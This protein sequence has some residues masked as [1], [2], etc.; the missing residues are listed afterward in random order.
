MNPPNSSPPITPYPEVP[1]MQPSQKLSLEVLE[2]REVPALFGTPWPNANNL[3][4]SFAQDWTSIAGYSQD[5]LGWGQPSQLFSKM[6]GAGTAT[7]WQT[8]ILRAFQTWAVNANINIGL[9]PD[10]GSPFGPLSLAPNAGSSGDIRIGAYLASP[11][12]IAINQPY[13]PISGAWSGDLLYN[14]SKSFSIGNKLASFDLFT[15]TLNEA[16]NIFGLEDRNDPNSALYGH[17]IGVKAGLIAADVTALQSLYGVRT[18]D[19][20]DKAKNNDSINTQTVLAPY[21]AP[22][23]S[24]KKMVSANGADLTTLTD[25][26]HYEFKVNTTSMTVRLETVGKSL[27]AAK[28]SVYDSAD[29]FIATATSA[30]PLAMQDLV[31]TVNGLTAGKFYTV[32]VEKAADDAFGIGKYDL[33][34]GFG[35]NPVIP[36]TATAATFASDGGTNESISTASALIAVSGSANTSYLELGRI[37]SAT[38]VD[39]YKLNSPAI[40]SA[41]MTVIVDPAR[42]YGLYTKVTAYDA[43]GSVVP[44]EVLANGTD[45]RLVIQVAN[46]IASKVYSLKVQSVGRN[47][48]GTTGD[49]SLSVDFTRPAVPMTTVAA[50]T[51]TASRTIDYTTFAVPEAKVFH[52]TLNATTT[53]ASVASGVRMIIYNANSHIIASFSTDAGTTSTGAVMLGSGTYYMR[54]EGAT[55]TGVPLA[56]LSYS[57]RTVVLSDPI[58]PYAPPDPTNPPPL[59]PDYTTNH[60]ADPFYIALSLLNPW[61]NPWL[62]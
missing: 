27:L 25:V 6:A 37:E 18:L 15:T 28:V 16:G 46:P 40:A 56:N 14:T 52:F 45:G 7:Q 38:D 34:V 24:T 9:V 8:E 48:M 51:L 20:F 19:A 49:Y 3:T 41:P 5:V 59:P 29:R 55:K 61:A 1:I 10:G 47:G 33:K 12:V 53:D 13:N 21:A 62:P 11:E 32:R 22:T 43:S 26:D 58:D 17:Y 54:F 31:L 36:A 39:F 42:A 35:F 2:A 60:Q 44:S 23:D 50:T 57:L 4:L 30:G